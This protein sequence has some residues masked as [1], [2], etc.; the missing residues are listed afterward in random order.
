MTFRSALCRLSKADL[1]AVPTLKQTLSPA[2]LQGEG[3][4]QTG[5]HTNQLNIFTPPAEHLTQKNRS[6]K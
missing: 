5:N 4:R 2:P 6:K 3:K 1:Q